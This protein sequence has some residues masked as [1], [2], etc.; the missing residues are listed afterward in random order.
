[1]RSVGIILR[2]TPLQDGFEHFS[3]G[4]GGTPRVQCSF[5]L[6]KRYCFAE[7]LRR[8]RRKI[9][10][11][12]PV[13]LEIIGNGIQGR[14]GPYEIAK[15]RWAQGSGKPLLPG[16]EFLNSGGILELYLDAVDVPHEANC[17]RNL[18]AGRVGANEC[19]VVRN[20]RS[21]SPPNGR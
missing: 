5:C 7:S 1:M 3:Q 13:A 4:G 16:A 10:L 2:L 6:L 8:N 17:R 20:L 19:E 18:V 15:A 14:V 21:S 11:C 12:Q 9:H